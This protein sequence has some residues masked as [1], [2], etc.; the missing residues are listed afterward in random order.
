M[1]GLDD[2]LGSVLGGQGGGGLG[3][4]LGG[5]GGAGGAG[6]LLALAPVVAGLLRGGGLQKL[7]SQF[8]Q[9]GMGDK[10]DSWVKPGDNHPLTGDEVRSALGDDQVAQAAQQLGVSEDEA[11][12][13]LA[14]VIPATVDRLT[15]DGAVPADDEIDRLVAG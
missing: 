1:S 2:I 11:A 3:G 5:G 7:L 12:A 6:A 9:K 15:P 10:A 4:I 14:Q 8:Q 13:T